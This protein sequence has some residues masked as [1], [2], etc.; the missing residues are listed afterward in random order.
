MFSRV[1]IIGLPLH[2]GCLSLEFLHFL[3]VLLPHYYCYLASDPLV[4]VCIHG[5][6]DD[7]S[8]DNDC[9][10]HNPSDQ[11][12][13]LALS[14]APPGASE[15]GLCHCFL[16]PQGSWEVLLI[17]AL[18]VLVLVQVDFWEE[19]SLVY[20]LSC[21]WLL[22]CSIV[23]SVDVLRGRKSTKVLRNVKVSDV[24]VCLAT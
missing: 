4:L 1:E 5:H 16:L 2:P 23:A 14:P 8:H 24:S 10:Y 19:H 6:N 17:S 22:A 12:H 20:L 13:H 21:F 15:E 7:H 18:T 9:G 3:L 11:G